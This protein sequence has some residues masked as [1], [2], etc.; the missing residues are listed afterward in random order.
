[1]VSNR[2]PGRRLGAGAEDLAPGSKTWR[3]GRRLAAGA[4]DLAPGSKTGAAQG[5][6]DFSNFVENFRQVFHLKLY[7]F[8]GKHVFSSTPSCSARSARFLGQG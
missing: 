7:L 3:P 1:M 5:K 6:D 4:E 8:N 2:L